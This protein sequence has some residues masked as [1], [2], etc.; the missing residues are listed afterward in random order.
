MCQM[1]GQMLPHGEGWITHI[2]YTRPQTGRAT[3]VHC[4]CNPPCSGELSEL[5]SDV[6]SLASLRSCAYSWIEDAR[7]SAP[8]EGTLRWAAYSGLV[9][10]PTLGHHTT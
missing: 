10:T 7:Y 1:A 5:D 3:F 2:L 9:R 8:A 6:H 4:T